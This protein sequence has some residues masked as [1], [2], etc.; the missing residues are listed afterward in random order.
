[1]KQLIVVVAVVANA[2]QDV[3]NVIVV[4]SPSA[5]YPPTT[6]CSTCVVK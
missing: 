3:P 1:M 6:V 2:P 5:Q 4:S